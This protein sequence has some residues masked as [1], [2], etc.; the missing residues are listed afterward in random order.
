VACFV[1]V[2]AYDVARET[3]RRR[4][5]VDAMRRLVTLSPLADNSL[6]GTKGT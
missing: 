6:K 3:A 1:A 4:V 5:D 2:V